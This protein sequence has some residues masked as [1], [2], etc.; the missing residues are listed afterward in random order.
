M[1]LA[2]S[3]GGDSRSCQSEGTVS[4]VVSAA[5]ER[6]DSRSCQSEG[7]IST[8]ARSAAFGRGRVRSCLSKGT[9]VL[10]VV[11][12]RQFF[13]RVGA[14]PSLGFPREI[15]TMGVACVLR[16]LVWSTSFSLCSSLGDHA[17]GL[18]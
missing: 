11:R 1:V 17:G 6:G 18:A 14:S 9:V 5:S 8:V 15:V 3:E 2:A 7:T 4:T 13:A 16:P 10:L 12:R